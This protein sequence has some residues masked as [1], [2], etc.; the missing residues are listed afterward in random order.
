MH[1]TCDPKGL[2]LAV[3][4]YTTLSTKNHHISCLIS[5]LDCTHVGSATA[6][7]KTFS[8]ENSITEQQMFSLM[9]SYSYECMHRPC[10]VVNLA[11]SIGPAWW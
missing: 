7:F 2:M 6:S 1:Y 9:I 4:M 8:Q 11:M 10:L 3:P 5:V